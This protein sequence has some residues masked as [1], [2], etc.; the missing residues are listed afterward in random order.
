MMTVPVAPPP[1]YRPPSTLQPS[2]TSPPMMMARVRTRSTLAAARA[3]SCALARSLLRRRFARALL[4]WLRDGFL[5]PPRGL[6]RRRC[7]FRLRRPGVTRLI[8]AEPPA[9]RQRE[10]RAQPPAEVLHHRAE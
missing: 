8:D 10:L 6:A 5:A 4:R 7:G 1:T 9:S 2:S 3:G